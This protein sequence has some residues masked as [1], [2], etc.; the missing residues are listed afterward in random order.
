M[1]ICWM[2]RVSQL[3]FIY[4]P[5]TFSRT[6]NAKQINLITN[7]PACSHANEHVVFPIIQ[8]P[9]NNPRSTQCKLIRGR[10]ECRLS[11]Q[12]E[13]PRIFQEHQRLYFLLN[14]IHI[15]LFIIVCPYQNVFTLPRVVCVCV[16]VSNW[17]I[18]YVQH[19]RVC[20]L[21]TVKSDELSFIWSA[22]FARFYIYISKSTPFFTH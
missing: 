14:I 3:H 22:R 12:S 1:H 7:Y 10:W 18:A 6:R 9:A 20:R 4:N 8:S 13:V 17:F 2:H 5:F 16:F 11:R 15:N 21:A 19:F